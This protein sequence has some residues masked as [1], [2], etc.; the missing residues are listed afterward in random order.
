VILAAGVLVVVA[1][2]FCFLLSVHFK[3]LRYFDRPTVARHPAFDRVLLL[4]RWILVPSGL[5]L[6]ARASWTAFAVVG[7]LLVLAWGW[8]R[9]L[10]SIPFQARIVR[11]EYDLL[12]RRHPGAAEEDLLRRLAWRRHPAWG[13]ELIDQMVRDYPT[14]GALSVMMVRM[15]R[16]FRGFRGGVRRGAARSGPGPRS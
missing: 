2:L 4:A 10:R 8:R 9:V 3:G 14:I 7:G 13:E 1:G 12:R 6:T 15:E 11:R 5:A 16:G